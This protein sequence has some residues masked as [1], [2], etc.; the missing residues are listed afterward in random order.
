MQWL[1]LIVE[2]ASDAILMLDE[3]GSVM[4]ANMAAQA[5]LGRPEQELQG[6]QFGYVV[7][8]DEPT[9]I[10]LTHPRQGVIAADLRS[11]ELEL[12]G[13][14]V[15]AVYLRDISERKQ[16]EL[17]LREQQARLRSL[18]NS[19]AEAIYETDREG[20]FTFV[21]RSCLALLGYE[22]D[23]QLLGRDA[24][25][26]IHHSYANGTPLSEDTCHA[27]LA[28]T[29]GT[30]THSTDE[31]F[32]RCDGSS[33]PVEFR[34]YPVHHA[35][36]LVGSV[37]TFL[38]I[39]E[40]RRTEESLRQSAAVFEHTSE[41]VV[42]TDTAPRIVAVN[43]AF[44]NITGY[45][46]AE[47]LGQN[48]SLLKSGR[49][50]PDFYRQ[51]WQAINRDGTWRGEIWNRRK[52]GETY[53]QWLN[54]SCVREDSGTV[55]H[56]VG[57][58][59][60]IT[61]IKRS[62]AELERLAHRDA[63]TGLPN[64]L[65]FR[66]RL[67]HAMLRADRNRGMIAVLFVD[68]DGFKHINDSFG[69]TAG[70]RVLHEVASRFG[71]SVRREDTVARLG[72]DEFTVLVEDLRDET[73]ASAL[74]GK[75]IQAMTAPILLEQQEVFVTVSVGIAIYPRDGD[76]IEALLGN[77]DAA[78]YR[79]KQAGRNRYRYYTR[80]LTRYA[81]DRVVLAAELR[82]AIEQQ[83]LV[84]HYQPQVDLADGHV[85]GLEALVRWQHP[86]E[87]LV[88]P[89]RFIPMAEETGLI[90]L[91]GEWV[92]HTACRQARAWLDQG[93]RFGQ[94]AVNVSGIQFQHS[95]IVGTVAAVLEETGLAP[96]MLELEVT[97]SSIMNQAE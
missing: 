89:G 95:D 2:R 9:E 60:D 90:V 77:A 18:M 94:V 28:F 5:L 21:N 39:S 69:H 48:P 30:P 35:G 40:R 13:R 20:R 88:S 64:R 65:L 51:M 63:L 93:L 17:R 82:R 23:D 32:W 27:R 76:S 85:V 78:M 3:G 54:I 73:G 67:E 55:S 4:Y 43:R 52:D 61:A 44:A 12:D 25:A 56:Y 74:A 34:A 33:F 83:E 81:R 45:A 41:G 70:D 57:V 59:S 29:R 87:G 7:T 26:V 24:H 38:D 50:D 11:V 71:K 16:A 75:L 72:G 19:I 1:D 14:P 86:R 46:E 6:S 10:A 49:H 66:S 84:L 91:L 15:T 62:Q 58:F 92:L 80:E 36:E 97:E 79:A 47:A 8:P 96:G 37:V 42:I 53:P 22:S 68:L 31:V